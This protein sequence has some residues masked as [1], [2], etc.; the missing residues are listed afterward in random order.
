MSRNDQLEKMFVNRVRTETATVE[1]YVIDIDKQS[2]NPAVKKIFNPFH[3]YFVAGYY[4][5]IFP[6]KITKKQD[7]NGWEIR[8]WMVLKWLSLLIWW[9]LAWVFGITDLIV[10][11][12][13][14]YGSMGFKGN[15]GA[16]YYF[17]LAAFIF[18]QVLLFTF[19]RI[20]MSKR[21]KLEKLFKNVSAFSLFN[22]TDI[23]VKTSARVSKWQKRFLTAYTL[24][25]AILLI[26]MNVVKRLVYKYIF[27]LEAAIASARN[28]FFL[29]A[30]ERNVTL[31]NEYGNPDTNDIYSTENIIAVFSEMVLDF[32]RGCNTAF[33]LVCFYST[34]P[35]T[36][37]FAS[38]RFQ[39]Y[40]SGIYNPQVGSPL[41]SQNNSSLHADSILEKHEE[42]RNLVAT[43]NSIWSP[44]ILYY[45]FSISLG[46]IA[47]IN[48][49]I[50]AA[51][52]VG[53]F[54]TANLILFFLV[55][56]I[57]LAEGRRMNASMKLFLWD[58]HIREQVFD[59]RRNE[60]EWL[61][62]YLDI[63]P[64]GIGGIG[65]Y[66]IS[67]GFLAQLLVFMVTVFLISF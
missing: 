40:L 38:K 65:S 17:D 27:S 39:Q 13:M 57:L 8:Y 28:R 56:L 49:V 43:L 19:Y 54:H 29:S 50:A 20:L 25:I 26:V 4:A 24:Y 35:L 2:E 42:L 52:L 53:I 37:W 63:G 1:T 67:Y 30:M 9:P 10:R 59:Q 12:K 16:W 31:I 41:Q 58:R 22:Q 55:S 64:V 66:E 33:I 51:D 60:L 36:L 14:F 61:E 62:R 48:Q 5:L 32:I 34:L 46:I 3:W 11:L 15:N 47:H 7:G 21:E 45:I 18:E 44:S 23:L 6:F